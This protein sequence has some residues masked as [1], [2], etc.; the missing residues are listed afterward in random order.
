MYEK[1]LGQIHVGSLVV[2]PDSVRYNG[3]WL[4]NSG[5]FCCGD[6]DHFVS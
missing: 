2:S 5:G 1:D 6:N 3:Q 4:I